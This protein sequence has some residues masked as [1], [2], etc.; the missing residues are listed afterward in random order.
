[1]IGF[2]RLWN[3]LFPEW[4]ESSPDSADTEKGEGTEL[5]VESNDGEVCF[6]VEEVTISVEND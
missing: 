4:T 2:S 3:Y 6:T 1:M 5:T